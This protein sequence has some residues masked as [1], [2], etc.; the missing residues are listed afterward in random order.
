[1][2]IRN[3]EKL[4]ALAA[5]LAKVPTSAPGYKNWIQRLDKAAQNGNQE[6]KYTLDKTMEYAT[7]N[8][9][10]YSGLQEFAMATTAGVPGVGS[11]VG[12]K[13][14]EKYGAVG[15]VIGG[16][17]GGLVGAS[18][19]VMNI[20]RNI[21]KSKPKKSYKNFTEYDI[22][23]VRY[24]DEP[25]TVD[26]KISY[27]AERLKSGATKRTNIEEDFNTM[28]YFYEDNP[29]LKLNKFNDTEKV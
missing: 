28:P 6:A 7:A 2:P 29:Y 24:S 9:K 15:S 12:S 10:S 17:L 27:L 19:D 13:A 8:R 3:K 23:T 22:G 4:E 14:G 11:F 5:K 18:H 1:M 16:V 21:K 20:G 26:D 25:V